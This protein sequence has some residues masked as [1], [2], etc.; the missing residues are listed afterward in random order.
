MYNSPKKTTPLQWKLGKKNYKKVTPYKEEQ[1]R[2]EV[3][4]PK[5]LPTRKF[6]LHCNVH[7]LH[8]WNFLLVWFFI[9]DYWAL[10]FPKQPEARFCFV[11]L[12]NKSATGIYLILE[13]YKIH[14]TMESEYIVVMLSV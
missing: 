4:Q 7:F 10:Y 8:T 12:V 13:S 5:T 11:I 3:N 2:P 1:T 14:K 6:L 9:K